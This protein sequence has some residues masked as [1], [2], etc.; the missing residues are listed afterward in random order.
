MSSNRAAA[1][2]QI[3]IETEIETETETETEIGTEAA[4]VIS[5]SNHIQI[6]MQD[7]DG[8]Q[9]HSIRLHR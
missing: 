5:S 1:D 2:A 4:S 3:E 7:R 8:P 9:L 6:A